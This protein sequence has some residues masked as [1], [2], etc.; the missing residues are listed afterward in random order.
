MSKET[1]IEVCSPPKETSSTLTSRIRS[2]IHTT[3]T[4]APS[5]R[6]FKR[7]VVCILVGAVIYIVVIRLFLT[8]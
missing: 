1:K 8:I 6:R 3:L 7:D 4:D 2:W 5:R